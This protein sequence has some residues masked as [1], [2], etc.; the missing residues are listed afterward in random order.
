MS[1]KK[2]KRSA[3]WQI[4]FAY[5]AVSKI[6]YWNDTILATLIQGDF[7]AVGEVVLNRLLGRDILII[8]IIL[9][10]FNTEKLVASKISKYNKVVN[11]II[12]HI[13]DYVLYIG[14]LAIYFWMMILFGVFQNPN[15]GE[16]LI[17]YSILY[18]V[19][20]V[21]MEIKKFFKKKETQ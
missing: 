3:I 20:V 5:L 12:V 7:R 9:L 16:P 13:I 6:L 17:Y 15:L 21:V 1:E 11:Q 14:V 2:E 10:T 18:V 4:L 19:I 8:L